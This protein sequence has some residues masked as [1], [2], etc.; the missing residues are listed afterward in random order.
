MPVMFYYDNN[1]TLRN[2]FGAYTRGHDWNQGA[3]VT[4]ALPGGSNQFVLTEQGILET[5]TSKASQ[6]ATTTDVQDWARLYK[7]VYD[8]V[9]GKTLISQYTF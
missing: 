3:A 6:F 7:L 9:T 2:F 8:I 5:L 4:D 1:Q